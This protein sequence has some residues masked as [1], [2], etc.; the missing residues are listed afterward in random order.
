LDQNTGINIINKI[1]LLSE[2]KLRPEIND[3]GYKNASIEKY[4]LKSSF[5]KYNG[6]DDNLFSFI[7]KG[8]WSEIPI[9]NFYQ[10]SQKLNKN[11]KKGDKKDI[12]NTYRFGT[13]ITV[14][15][16]T[17]YNH[18]KDSSLISSM[19]RKFEKNKKQIVCLSLL[20]PCNMKI[21]C[22]IR[23]LAS[24][25]NK[26]INVASIEP[27]I[28]SHQLNDIHD[29]VKFISFPVGSS[30]KMGIKLF[31]HEKFIKEIGKIDELQKQFY[32]LMDLS[33]TESTFKSIVKI[34]EFYY[35]NRKKIILAYHCKS[36]RDRTGI[37]DSVVQAT[38]YQLNKN[39]II[40]YESI[41]NYSQFFLLFGLLIAYRGTGFI[42]LK[43]GTNKKLAE[44]IFKNNERMYDFFIGHS[45]LAGSSG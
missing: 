17:G 32:D 38:F 3:I 2:T 29:D 16:D 42:G 12:I 28:I 25:F 24:S 5:I 39:G 13:K 27:D 21:G 40:D 30:K 26:K 43:L 19:I 14:S 6:L 20:T 22:G 15:T 34:A 18:I 23:K 35:N 11:D 10:V 4:Q 33:N 36:G 9:V 37:F 41:R 45:N 31:D 1:P 44:Y 7:S 8:N